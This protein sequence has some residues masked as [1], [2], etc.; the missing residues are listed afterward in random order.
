MLKKKKKKPEI[1]NDFANN[2]GLKTNLY[3]F[4]DILSCDEW[5]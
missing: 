4:A 1:M 3:E 5:A 2:L